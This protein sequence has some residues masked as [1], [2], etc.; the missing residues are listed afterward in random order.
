MK[1][2]WVLDTKKMYWLVVKNPGSWYKLLRQYIVITLHTVLTSYCTEHGNYYNTQHGLKAPSWVIIWWIT[3]EKNTVVFLLSKVQLQLP[4][5]F[6]SNLYLMV[7]WP[8][9]Y[10]TLWSHTLQEISYQHGDFVNRTK[11]GSR[12][13]SRKSPV[14][15]SLN[16]YSLINTIPN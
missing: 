7:E 3:F 15:I 5:R 8:L 6:K 12:V 10:N 14:G 13:S 4:N 9:S 16:I 11:S 2:N 1:K